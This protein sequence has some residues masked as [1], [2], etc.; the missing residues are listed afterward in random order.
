MHKKLLITTLLFE[1][2]ELLDVFGPLEMFGIANILN[3]EIELKFVSEKG[4]FSKS[5]A[6]PVSLVD[7]SFNDEFIS[8]ILFVPGGMG[9][10]IEVDND[11]LIKW[12]AK[13]CQNTKIIASVCTGAALL[14]KAGV[15]GTVPATTNKM[16]FEWVKSIDTSV[17]WVPEARWV[18]SGN[19]YTSSGISAG[20]DMA[21]A[22]IS[23]L[24]SQ[25]VA[26]QVANR[27]EYEWHKNPSYDP[28]A[29]LNGLV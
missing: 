17:K 24:F 18:K 22:I 25:E 23:E 1:N 29:K 2:F 19:I 13:H 12:L 10:R 21:L 20:M 6:G 5:S 3:A 27:A 4:G 14:A 28:F 7:Y 26:E 9:T 15:I 11:I 8:D 16:A